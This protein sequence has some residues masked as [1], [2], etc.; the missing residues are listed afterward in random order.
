MEKRHEPGTGHLM[1]EPAASRQEVANGENADVALALKIL[2]LNDTVMSLTD[3]LTRQK[4]RCESVHHRLGVLSTLLQPLQVDQPELLITRMRC[5][6][7]Q[8]S[9]I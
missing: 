3:E 6:T 2:A 7:Q 4:F 5:M 1:A 8:I 9:A